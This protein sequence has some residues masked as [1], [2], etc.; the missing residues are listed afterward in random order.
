MAAAGLRPWPEDDSEA[1]G[2]FLTFVVPAPEGCNLK[3]SF[4][5]IKQRRE[6]T[7]TSVRPSD[8]A[9]FI[10]EAA[11]RALIYALAIQGYEPLLPASLPYTQ[12]V[13]ATGRLLRIPTA[14]VTN[15]VQLAD[16]VDLLSALAPDKIAISLD[17]AA[18]ENHDRMRG[19]A[20]AWIATIGGL[21]R[22]AEVLTPRTRLT[23][24]S[25][26]LPGKPHYL[27]DMPALLRQMGIDYW[28]VNPLL[29]I[30]QDQ[31][32]GVADDR[33]SIF[34]DLL[35]LQE[36][37]DR[38]GVHLTVDDEF[39]RLNRGAERAPGSLDVRTLPRDVKIFRLSPGG[40]CSAGEDILRQVTPE[41][42]RWLPDDAHAGEFLAKLVA[43]KSQHHC[44][45]I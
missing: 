38:A 33:D 12:A 45:A 25:V 8:L 1:A 42:P 31:A 11:E 39:A 21:R 27:R 22:A 2:Q 26:L 4:C 44:R 41:A 9:R 6:I 43:S 3:C 37:A 36:A 20:G 32:G 17:S 24:S 7:Q 15:G 40:H 18:A 34:R 30:G 16:S 13:L 10:R 23:V 29:R 35:V 14:I 19:V 28:I 5:L